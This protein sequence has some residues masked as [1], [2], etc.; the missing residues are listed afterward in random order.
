MAT[1]RIISQI[2]MLS[3]GVPKL[4]KA[5]T[6]AAARL[7]SLGITVTGTCHYLSGQTSSSSAS[8]LYDGA[9]DLPATFDHG[10]FW[11][12]L[13]G[14]LQLID[15]NATGT[16]FIRKYTQYNLAEFEGTMLAAADETKITD[17]TTTLRDINQIVFGNGSSSTTANWNIFLVD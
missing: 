13:S 9:S 4:I 6:A 11:S 2:A 15:V 7:H 16:N 3:A 12:D 8:T 1:L 17:G 14:H 5:G 10:Y